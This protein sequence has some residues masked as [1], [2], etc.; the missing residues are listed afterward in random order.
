M[1]FRFSV[2]FVLTAALAVAT[3]LFA[4][5]SAPGQNSPGQSANRQQT[6]PAAPKAPAAASQSNGNPFPGS[7]TSVPILPSRPASNIPESSYA[8]SALTAALPPGDTDPVRSPD[9]SLP[10]GGQQQGFSDSMTG[11]G[12]ILPPADTA[13]QGKGKDDG[14]IATLPV[15]SP[16][17]DVSVGNY[18]LSNKNWH[19]ALSRFQSALVLDPNNPD[20]YWGL[21]ESERNLGDYAAARGH[22]LKV[23]EFDPG[24]RHAR[25]A[26]KA[27]RAPEIA[28]AKPSSTGQAANANPQ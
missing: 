28:N 3:P 5:N 25:D 26:E 15:E 17:N 6:A 23:L 18:Y 20:V 14:Q 7:T 2:A 9:S 10:D 16:A 8:P 21:A 27:L 24:S 13:P 4:Q 12:D 1:K 19:A 11:I 22:F